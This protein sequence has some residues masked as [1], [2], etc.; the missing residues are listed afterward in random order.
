[1]A[2]RFDA[3]EGYTSTLT[4]GSQTNFSFTCWGY[5]S[6]DRN[7]WSSFWSFDANLDGTAMMLQTDEDGQS[8]ILYDDNAPGQVANGVAHTV[9]Q[10]YFMAVTV[11][12]T[13]GTLYWR[14][15]NTQTLSTDTWTSAARTIT[16]LLIGDNRYGEFLNGRVAAFKFWQAGLTA[17]EVVQESQQYQ[18]YRTSNLRVYLPFVTN[19]AVDFSGN[20]T[21]FTGGATTTR[22]D[23]PPIPWGPR[24]VRYVMPTA[25]G[26]ATNVPVET[27]TATGVAFDPQVTVQ[28]PVGAAAATGTAFD[29]SVST[30]V[31][32]AV[33]AATG[34]GAANDPAI[35][36]SESATVGRADAIGQAFDPGS[37]VQVSVES[38]SATGQAFDVV[39]TTVALVNV[40]VVAATGTGVANDV[41][42]ATSESALPG[43]ALA[44]GEALDVA[45]A[46]SQS[47]T[48][49]TALATGAAQDVTSTIAVNVESAA[50][51]GRAFDVDVQTA[52]ETNVDVVEALGIGQAYDV[53][54][55][56][57]VSPSVETATATGEALNPTVTTGNDAVVQV[58]AALATGLAVDLGSALLTF[59]SDVATATGEAFDA[60]VT[61]L[62]ETLV[63]VGVATGSGAAVDVTIDANNDQLVAV[64]VATGQGTAFDV[65]VLGALPVGRMRVRGNEPRRHASG[66]DTREPGRLLRGREP[67][68]DV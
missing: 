59:E 49:D 46:T 12:G 36:T 26:T 51:T 28:V 34:T 62:A 13:S 32:V 50:A 25:G 52:A 56:A 6:T 11:S 5:I 18:P 31:N 54:T 35:T 20:G 53:V 10:W 15:A 41:T 19:A 39:A 16:R 17:A 61:T 37:S 29:A 55:S 64:G 22:E 45:V 65:L 33:P 48:P 57:S 3:A 30:A 27:A 8:L 63:P 58:E 60:A 9:G 7:T 4:L 43:V 40:D 23:G 14:A 68:S 44:T 66:Y 47:V 21:T 38:V 1:M 42:V 67:R 2:V 24:Q